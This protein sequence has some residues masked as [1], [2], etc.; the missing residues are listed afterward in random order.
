MSFVIGLTGSI[1]M[2]KST[3]AGLFAEEGVPIWDADD[4][5]HRLYAPGGA[6][7]DPMRALNPE[8]IVE[9]GV[10][11]DALKAWIATD[12]TALK[13]IEG[14]V[15]PLV[16]EDRRAFLAGT[17]A[18]IVLLDI[19]LLFE[20]TASPNVDAVV[21]VSAPADVQRA[22]VMA[23]GTMDEATFEMILGKQ[24]PDADKRARADY[25]IETTSVDAAR[26]Q[27]QAVLTEIRGKLP[28]A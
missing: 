25:V 10:S 21:V 6:A 14:I 8:V 7:V 12:L 16:A 3:T 23:R 28:H 17:D 15:H 24:V 4:A 2:G 1:G 22:R 19:P 13:Q 11:R 27:V 26:A 9:G 5:V 20:N 18:E